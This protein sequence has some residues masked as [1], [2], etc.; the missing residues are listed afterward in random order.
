VVRLDR[1]IAL[2]L[3]SSDLEDAPRNPIQHSGH[4]NALGKKESTMTS[5]QAPEEPRV[6]R[7]GDGAVFRRV[8]GMHRTR[9]IEIF[10][11]GRAAATGQVVAACYNTMFTGAPI[12]ASRDTAPQA[13][14][15]GIDFDALT[16]DLGLLGASLNG[17]KIWTPDWSEAQVGTLRSFNGIDAPWV[18]QLDMKAVGAVA[19]VAPYEPMTIA[20]DSRLGWSSGTP[21][22]LLDDADGGT[23]IMKGFQLGLEPRFDYDDVLAN[24]ATY[25]TKL[26]PGWSFRVTTL[27]RELIETPAGGVATIMSDEFFNVYDR[28]GPVQMNFTP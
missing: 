8:D 24:G 23:W 16:A 2:G 6:L 14:V 20:R 19:D 26:P 3:P 18:G 12:P 1:A 17:P 25:F 28:T 9:Y 27:E 22:M 4:A 13:L 21:V 7:D 15:A 5:D 11:A 10:L